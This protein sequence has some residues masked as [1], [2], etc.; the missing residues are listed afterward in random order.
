MNSSQVMTLAIYYNTSEG[1]TPMSSL[2]STWQRLTVFVW[3][4]L[5]R[6]KITGLLTGNVSAEIRNNRLANNVLLV[7][8]QL[9]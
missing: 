4:S 1:C 6:N 7:L 3:R 5:T 9:E 2:P 8:K